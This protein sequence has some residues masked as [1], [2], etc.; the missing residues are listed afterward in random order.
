MRIKSPL[1]VNMTVQAFFTPLPV[2]AFKTRHTHKQQVREVNRDGGM[3]VLA[4]LDERMMDI[5]HPRFDKTLEQV[6][7]TQKCQQSQ[8]ENQAPCDKPASLSALA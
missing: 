1:T 3:T 7:G 8:T 6:A 4:I 5:R 2:L